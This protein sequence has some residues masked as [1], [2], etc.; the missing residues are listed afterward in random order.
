MQVV[1][2]YSPPC[3]NDVHPCTSH[4]V[5]CMV[6]KFPYQSGW[7]LCCVERCNMGAGSCC[8]VTSSSSG[9][10]FSVV[11]DRVGESAWSAELSSPSELAIV[12]SNSLVSLS[13][14]PDEILCL[15]TRG[16]GGVSG[17]GHCPKGWSR[18]KCTTLHFFSFLS[19][20][21]LY[22]TLPMRSTILNGP[23]HG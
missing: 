12:D 7:R 3:E 23:C 15:D 6:I 20:W 21:I 2:Y 8:S 11:D 22:K 17:L 14:S 5:V 13:D 19:S 16:M 9:F 1:L 4:R 10:E 18:L